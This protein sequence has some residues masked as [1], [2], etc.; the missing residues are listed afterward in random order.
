M[1]FMTFTESV[2][3]ILDIPSMYVLPE[4]CEA[5]FSKYA[6]EQIELLYYRYKY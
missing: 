5:V 6:R 1:R 2:P 4:E 3:N